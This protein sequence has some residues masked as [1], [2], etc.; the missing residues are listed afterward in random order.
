MTGSQSSPPFT[1][2]AAREVIAAGWSHIGEQVH[3]IEEAVNANPGLAFDLAKTL[4]ESV[5]RT[6]LRERGLH[7]DNRWDLPRLLKETLNQMRL[8]PDQLANDERASVSLRKTTGGLLTVIQGICELRN[9]HGFASHGRDPSFQQLE[10]VHALLV[11]R[12]TDAI[13]DFIFRAHREY[14]ASISSPPLA[15]EDNPDFN[16]YVD[17]SNERVRIF[18][19]EYRPSEVLFRVD[20]AAYEEFLAAFRNQSEPEGSIGAEGDDR[21]ACG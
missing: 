4:L 8:V 17:A 6:V 15:Y 9:T 21:E 7:F 12:A 2:L 10:P 1:M 13:V 19:L 14:S 5:C 3:A 11:A 16:E 18:D 20:Q